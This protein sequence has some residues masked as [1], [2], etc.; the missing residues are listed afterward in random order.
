MA[1]S[2]QGCG[3]SS[4]AGQLHL[5]PME[6]LP[7]AL[8]Q[9]PSAVRQAYQFAA[10]NPEVLRAL[11]CYCGCGNVGHT[12]NL[13]CYIT[14]LDESGTIRFDNHALGCTLCVDITHDAMRLLREGH[15]LPALREF[16][17]ARYARFGPSNMP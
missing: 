3:T 11:P 10:A 15:E 12:S 9:A 8:Q 6:D 7:E 14:K 13:D 17:D 5:M 2:L 1:I 4:A 16:V